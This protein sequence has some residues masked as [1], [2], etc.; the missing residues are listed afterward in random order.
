MTTPDG[1]RVDLL[2]F[3]TAGSVDDGKSTLVGR[4]LFDANAIL[5]DQLAQIE[6]TSQRLDGPTDLSLVTDGLRAER[7]QKI[8]I[9]VAY[10]YFK[11]TKRRFIIADTPG[12][13]Q[14]TRNMVTGAS[15]A[16]LAVILVDASKGVLAQSRRHVFIA[17]LLGLPQVIVAVNKMDLAGYSQMRYEAVVAEFMAVSAKLGIPS[18]R[19][20]P[21]SALAGDNVVARSENMPWYSGAALLELL[22]SAPAARRQAIGE[23]RFPVQYVIRPHQQFRG[24]AGTI[25]SGAVQ[26]GDEIVVLPSGQTTRV[27][28]IESYDGTLAQASSGEA[29]VLTTTDELDMSRGDLIV[30]PRHLPRSVSAFDAD[31]C[32][33]HETPLAL[34]RAYVML[35]TTQQVQAH[36]TLIHH[37]IDMDTLDA[38]PAESLEMNDVGRVSISAGRAIH[39]DAYNVNAVMGG[40]V[41]V[42]PQSNVTVA[43]GMIRPAGDVDRLTATPT[44]DN[45]RWSSWNIPRDERERRNGHPAAVVWLT[46]LPGSGKTTIAR[47]VER[48]LF[49]RGYQTMLLDGDQLRHGLCGDLGFSPAERAE[50]IRRAGEAAR[51]F[52]EQGSLVLCAFVSPYRTDRN[53]VRALLPKGAFVE[54]FVNAPLETCMQRDPKG[55]YA[56]ARRGEVA[57]L[58]GL[59]APYEAPMEAEV[60]LDTD[61]SPIDHSVEELLQA[62]TARGLLRGS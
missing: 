11:T 50:N 53:H 3:L 44:S 21:V 4:L 56:R 22:E 5:D 47:A 62:L 26:A 34:E 27:D 51:L 38:A 43:A 2:R 48:R 15:T 23:F 18:I 40:F 41:L 58:T 1:P 24:Y 35:H 19:F 32:W 36:V 46:G 61:R 20:L 45:V 13:V 17:A 54:V 30:H 25:A 59:G 31:I 8:T 28:S 39:C 60:I 52:F 14:Y 55:L 9:D 57:Q 10:R 6:R 42:D 12:H 33:M 7:E 37:R 29:V 49:D 16:D